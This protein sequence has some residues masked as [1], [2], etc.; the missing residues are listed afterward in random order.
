MAKMK[1]VGYDKFNMGLPGNLVTVALKDYVH[2]SDLSSSSQVGR[3]IIFR[4]S[5]ESPDY[6][7]A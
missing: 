6:V 1:E 2:N 3:R 5:I 7:S 4:W